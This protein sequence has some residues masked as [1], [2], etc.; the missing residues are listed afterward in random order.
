MRARGLVK[1]DISEIA[2]QVK[3]WSADKEIDVILTTGGTGLTGRDVTVEAVK[4]LFDKTLEG[5]SILFHK[6]SLATIGLATLQSRSCA[7]LIDE[8]FVFS[9]PGSTGAVKQAWDEI[10]RDALD[11]RYRPSSLVDLIPRLKE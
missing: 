2:S 1:D 5:F 9:L 11:S 6:M 8:C 10:I 3:K 7:G 4:P